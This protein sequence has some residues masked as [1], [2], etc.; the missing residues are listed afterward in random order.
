[1]EYNIMKKKDKEVIDFFYNMIKESC[2]K[3]NSLQK[4]ASIPG[5]FMNFSSDLA[6]KLFPL[7]AFSAP[8]AAGG[9]YHIMN[10]EL[11]DQ[12]KKSKKKVNRLRQ[13]FEEYYE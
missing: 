11:E 7:L 9:L 3:G 1:M 8:F 4:K 12:R 6:F 5:A 10:N 2:D 13:Q